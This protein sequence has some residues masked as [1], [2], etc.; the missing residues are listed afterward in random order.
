MRQLSFHELRSL[1]AAQ[2]ARARR[3]ALAIS[4][5]IALAAVGIVFAL[6]RPPSGLLAT[7]SG[8]AGR[9]EIS[10]AFSPDGRTLAVVSASNPLEPTP[11]SIS[12]WNVA[13]RKWTATLSSPRCAG[14]LPVLFSPDGQTLALFTYTKTTCLWN[15]ATRKWTATLS[16]P[17]C[18]GALPVLF[19][20]DGQTLALFT[21]TKTTCLWNLATGQ[22]TTLTDPG[23]TGPTEGAFSPDGRTLAVA[24]C[25]SGSI[26]LWDLATRRVTATL[27]NASGCGDVYDGSR[28]TTMAF[29][30]DGSMLAVSSPAETDVWDLATKHVT[31]RLLDPVKYNSQDAS[32]DTDST[33]FSPDGML[34]A[35]DADGIV[36]LWNVSSRKVTATITPPFNQG[37][38][39]ASYSDNDVGID[40]LPASWTDVEAVFSPSGKI[41]ATNAAFGTGTYLYDVSTRKLL[42]TLTDPGTNTT[43]LPTVV[44]SPDGSMLAVVDSNGHTY[45][46]HM[47]RLGGY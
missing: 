1:L 45:L 5:A 38:A 41:L 14:A 15:V 9:T 26:Y 23:G 24:D 42:A 31:A 39:V 44:F 28:Y 10:A 25:G 16:S 8:P 37:R 18:A 7:L 17:R 33:A 32:I 47:P 13:T 2:P 43:Y 27:T 20:P 46:W 36:Y 40:P 12:L 4:V 29:S 22:E 30:P 3:L 35:G 11:G 19:S 6:Q 21:Y 34:A